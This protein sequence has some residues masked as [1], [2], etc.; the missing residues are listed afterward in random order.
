MS[1]PVSALFAIGLL[2]APLLS[3]HAASALP[4]FEPAACAFQEVPADW[5]KQNRIDCGWLH[6]RESR[7]KP[8][9]RTLKLWVAIARADAGRS[10]PVSPGRPRHRHGR[11]V[12][13]VLSPEQ[14]LA[15][16]AQ[17]PRHRVLR[18]AR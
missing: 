3:A 18:P 6:V 10:T 14:D 5:A 1:K 16:D 12:L 11:H 4:R 9:S 7:G 8:D 15:G 13:S 17:D 2:A